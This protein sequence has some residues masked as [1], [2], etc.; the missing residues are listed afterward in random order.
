MKEKKE[1]AAAGSKER[2]IYIDLIRLFACLCI[3]TVHFNA[4][5][6]GFE[7]FGKFQYENSLVPNRYFGVYL[8]EIGVSLFFLISGAAL[9][10][11]NETTSLKDFYKKRFLNIYPM[12]WIAFAA[13][14]GLSFIL[15]KRLAAVPAWK[16]IFSII[17][18]DG[19]LQTLGLLHGSFYQIGEWFLGCIIT[20][21]II[22]PLLRKGMKAVPALVWIAAL[23]LNIGVYAALKPGWVYLNWFFIRIPEILFGMTVV[24]YR[25]DRYPLRF[26]CGTL[27]WAC[28]INLLEKNVIGYYCW[29]TAICIV[30]F[31]VL[32]NIGRFIKWPAVKKVIVFAS[33]L[34]YPIFLVH[35][36]I[37]SRA[38][39]MVD[40]AAL[41]RKQ[42]VL[43]YIFYL[44]VITA[45]ALL[46]KIIGTQITQLFYRMLP[47]KNI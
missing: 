25:L 41:T 16:I 27:A 22:W 37:I 3:I 15:D 30:M 40:L 32:L 28:V 18:Y 21:Y 17:G 36:W 14:T 7:L 2:L 29:N 45:A 43:F 47:R 26:L 33:G 12:F 46:L 10:I 13:A 8:G 35:H 5:V 9:M 44:V 19:Y 42:V 24:K 4:T 39:K 6:S 11:S 1:T 34:T 20:L 38:A 31:A 23:L